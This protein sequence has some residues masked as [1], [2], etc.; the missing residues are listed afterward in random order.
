[1]AAEQSGVDRDILMEI[2][3]K[4]M[5][6]H[7]TDIRLRAMIN[8][9]AFTC[10][11]YPVRGQEVL[12]AAAMTTLRSDDYLVATYRGLH[13]HISKGVPLDLLL[14]EYLGKATGACK[15]KGGPMHITH[16]ESGVMV[17]TG[18]VGSG[19]PIAN[20]L[21]MAARAR[22][23]DRVALV[24]FGDGATNIGAFHEALNMAS[25]WKLPVIFF[26]QNNRYGEHTAYADST[27]APRVVDRAQ[28][29]GIRAV[30]IDGN[31]AG[32]TYI[33][34]KDAV[35]RARAGQ[36]PTLI[37][38]M[39]YR[40]MG[41]TLAASTEYMPQEFRDAASAADPLPR[42]RATLLEL[43]VTEAELDAC[44]ATIDEQIEMAVAFAV[45]SPPAD[46]SEVYLDV[47]KEEIA[48]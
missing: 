25:I 14:A 37:E 3:R 2:Y 8:A 26:C 41:H 29:Y 7:R 45:S 9:G 35:A 22:G 42:L 17:T 44:V 6:I 13:D 46:A 40:M 47:L 12:S 36:G 23:E 4:A 33:A 24:S 18:I 48:A 38:G 32:E 30:R 1:M 43:Q 28:G 10:V 20:G 27:G 16:P 39:V 31:D 5:L 34:V 19:L 21:A 15:G 11:Y